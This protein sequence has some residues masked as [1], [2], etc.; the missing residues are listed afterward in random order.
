MQRGAAAEQKQA[1]KAWM[2]GLVLAAAAAVVFLLLRLR[3]RPTEGFPS[4]VVDAQQGTRKPIVEVDLLLDLPVDATQES[5]RLGYVDST[6]PAVQD[7]APLESAR[8][9]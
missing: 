7:P 1:M 8:R 9:I 5:A 2:L 6:M 4:T 3:R